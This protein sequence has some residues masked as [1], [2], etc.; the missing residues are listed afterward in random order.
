[1]SYKTQARLRGDGLLQLR[2]TA[3]SANENVTDFERWV[4]KHMW[5]F[6]AQPGWVAAYASAMA[7]GST[8]PGNDESVITD[9]MILSAVQALAPREESTQ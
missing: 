6:S 4:T 7:N 3:C 1:M 5:E 9:G 8:E 2:I